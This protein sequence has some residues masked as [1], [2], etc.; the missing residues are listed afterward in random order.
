[1]SEF[2]GIFPYLV[3][4]FDTKTGKLLEA[5]TR[6][7][8][9][10]LIGAGVHGLS[11]LG[12]T[13]EFA[14]LDSKQRADLVRCVV[15]QTAGRVPVVAG[16]ASFATADAIKQA[17]QYV[18][19][20]VDGIVLIL[21]TFFPLPKSG[22][23][24]YF[25][26]V[27]EAVPDC[28]IVLYANPQFGTADLPPDVV[29]TLSWIPNVKYFKEATGNTGRILTCMNRVS[30]RMKMFSASAHIPLS[31]FRLGGAGWMAGPACL[32]PAQCVALYDLCQAGRWDEALAMQRRQWRLNELFA[33][34]SLAACVKAGLRVQ[35]IEVGDPIPPQE[36]LEGA[37]I[38]EIREALEA[39][40]QVAA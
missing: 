28:P 14:Y 15:E 3:S 17:Q 39:Q 4:P 9:D 19:L 5:A 25:R 37:A 2:A 38:E 27:A 26:T 33:K 31:V 10:H 24:S 29:E 20:G 32:I 7:L 12:S 1:M 35:G 6:Q 34:Y 16:V 21:Q 30:D 40:Q 13:G 8:V 11:P 36:P 23:E 18:K 22:V